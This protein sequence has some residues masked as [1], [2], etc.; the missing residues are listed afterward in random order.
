[1]GLVS[2]EGEKDA[3]IDTFEVEAAIFHAAISSLNSPL[4]TESF[5][6]SSPPTSSPLTMICGNVGQSFRTLRP[7]CHETWDLSDILISKY[8]H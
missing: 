2:W 7:A 5:K 3:S 1:M 4:W 8:D 6:M